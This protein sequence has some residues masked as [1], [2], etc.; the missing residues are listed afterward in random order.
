MD[1]TV[2]LDRIKTSMADAATDVIAAISDKV[3]S[4]ESDVTQ[5][6]NRHTR[7]ENQYNELKIESG[8]KQPKEY[9]TSLKTDLNSANDKIQKLETENGELK[10]KVTDFEKTTLYNEIAQKTNFDV[11]ALTT[12][13]KTGVISDKIKIEGDII[14]IDDKIFEDYLKEPGKSWIKNAL[15]GGVPTDNGNN[16]PNTTPNLP[17]GGTTSSEQTQFNS[18]D[19]VLKQMNFAIPK[20]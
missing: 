2:A 5:W 14:K 13:I 3:S 15:Q 6:K 19:V 8:D 17:T 18:V 10:N 4:L 9:I 16:T 20:T 11:N 12:L 1:F 7:I